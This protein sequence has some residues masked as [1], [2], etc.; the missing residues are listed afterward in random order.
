MNKPRQ[1]TTEKSSEIFKIQFLIILIHGTQNSSCQM[2]SISRSHA[3]GMFVFA[4]F[5][6]LFPLALDFQDIF[7]LFMFTVS[8]HTTT[9]KQSACIVKH[10][11]NT[12][13]ECVDKLEAHLLDCRAV[14]HQIDSRRTKKF[15][16]LPSKKKKHFD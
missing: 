7:R 11:L 6:G 2:L 5:L 13:R 8:W 15:I 12:K 1:I 3:S 16:Y 14:C 4:F 10:H 9:T